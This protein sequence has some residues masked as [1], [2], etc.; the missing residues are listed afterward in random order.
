MA[1]S[2]LREAS[3]RLTSRTHD[4]RHRA[5]CVVAQAVDVGSTAP[6]C[7]RTRACGRL[8]AAE[9]CSRRRAEQRVDVTSTSGKTSRL[10]VG[11][12]SRTLRSWA[13]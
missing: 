8:E 2:R 10:R 6:A 5:S 12:R 11:R 13:L 7:L 9:S 3:H 1:A 4:A